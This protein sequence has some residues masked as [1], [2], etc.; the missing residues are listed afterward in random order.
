M[1][2]DAATRTTGRR[3]LLF[4]VVLAAALLGVALAAGAPPDDGA[5]LDPRATGPLGAKGLVLTLEEL[6]G[7]VVITPRVGDDFD[8]ALVLRDDL[9]QAQRD[10]LGGWVEAGGTLLIADPGSSLHPG[11]IVGDTQTIFGDATLPRDE[12]TIPPL[13]ALVRIDP[14]GGVLYDR[15]DGAQTCFTRGDGAYVIAVTSGA[16]WIVATGGAGAFVNSRLASEDNAALAANV[17]VPE[18]GT[19]VAVLERASA[20]AVEGDRSLADLVPDRV[21]EALVQL[22]VAF[23]VFALWKGRRLGRPVPEAQPVEIAGSELVVAVGGLM[24]KA[25]RPEAAATQLR[26]DLRRDL[27]ARLGLPPTATAELI[28][29]VAATRTGVACD[30]VYEA[31]TSPPPTSADALVRVAQEMEQVR[32]DVLG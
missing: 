12:C 24:Q 29:D 26:N 27:T 30:R 2:A 17:L 20:G 13:E 3:S 10:E 8:T 4:W 11:T 16:G 1:S 19:R 14:S 15:D 31:L 32:N 7:A 28:A 5:P 23:I 6:G 9:T 18:A 22:L 21:R 25:G